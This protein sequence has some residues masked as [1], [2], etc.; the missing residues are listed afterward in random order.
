MFKPICDL[1]GIKTTK[2]RYIG[3]ER[4]ACIKCYEEHERKLNEQRTGDEG[5]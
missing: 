3:K 5:V 4:V 2:L 1:C